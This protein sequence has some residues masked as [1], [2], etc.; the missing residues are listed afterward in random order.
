MP[1]T[2]AYRFARETEGWRSPCCVCLSGLYAGSLTYSAAATSCCR[3]P[4]C[5]YILLV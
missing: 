3:A 1:P 2:T 4:G 5:V